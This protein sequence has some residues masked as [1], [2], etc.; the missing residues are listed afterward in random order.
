MGWLVT[1]SNVENSEFKASP[2]Q[3]AKL[4]MITKNFLNIQCTYMFF[5]AFGGLVVA[6]TVKYADNILKGFATSISII[7]SSVFSY[8]VLNDLIPGGYFIL[9]TGLVIL[10]TFMYGSSSL[11]TSRRNA[12]N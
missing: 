3:H 2:T 5:Q 9:G 1:L 11:F 12:K 6:M 7:V 4:I 8:L 10:A